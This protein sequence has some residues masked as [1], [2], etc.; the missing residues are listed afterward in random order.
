LAVED[1]TTPAGTFKTFKIE[2]NG[3][4][5]NA[6][7][8]QIYWIDADSGFRVK[9]IRVVNNHRNQSFNVNEVSTLITKVNIF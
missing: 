6:T 2:M 9:T 3:Q 1:I 8:N 5:D 4:H 7:I